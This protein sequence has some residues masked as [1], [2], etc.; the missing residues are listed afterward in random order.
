MFFLRHSLHFFTGSSDRVE[1][2]KGQDEGNGQVHAHAL[3]RHSTIE[4]SLCDYLPLLSLLIKT[5]FI[6]ACG[7]VLLAHRYRAPL[8]PLLVYGKTAEDGQQAVGRGSFWSIESLARINVPR[9]WFTHFYLLSS[10]LG[11]ILWLLFGSRS[12]L[13]VANS[14]LVLIHSLRRLWE[15]CRIENPSGSRM[16]IG[17]YLAGLAF[18]IFMNLAL[19]S[20]TVCQSTRTSLSITKT[21]CIAVNLLAQIVQHVEHRHLAAARAKC[22]P[23][24]YINLSQGLARYIVAPHYTAEIVIYLAMAVLNGCDSNMDLIVLWTIII[25]GTSAFQTDRWGRQKFADWGHR[26]ILIPLVF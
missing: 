2:E 6:G 5:Y 1:G 23:G 9:S 11:L 7:A 22:K 25:L 13:G 4:S 17:H 21:I 26:W 16:W 12:E 19:I 18:Y 20:T 10:C 8:K 3:M 24:E 14:I 15:T